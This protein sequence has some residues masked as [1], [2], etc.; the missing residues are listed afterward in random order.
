MSGLPRPISDKEAA[1]VQWLL[2]HRA[3]G[4]PEGPW[5][6]SAA[7]LVVVGGCECGCCS[8][9]FEPAS[10]DVRPIRDAVGRL[11]DGRQSGLILW[12]SNDVIQRLEIYDLDPD[13]SHAL[14]E[15]SALR[16]W[17]MLGG[18]M[19]REGDEQSRDR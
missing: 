8:V 17:E 4:E 3:P 10:S 2:D 11:E 18:E 13:A 7:D 9:D 6:R 12:G 5:S 14:P 16:T 15:V 1:I 19:L